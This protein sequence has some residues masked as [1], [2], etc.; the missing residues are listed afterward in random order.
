MPL[1][2]L[3]QKLSPDSE[4]GQF[5]GTANALSFAFSSIGAVLY[6]IAVG[7]L[8]IPVNR[9]FIACSVLMMCWLAFMVIRLRRYLQEYRRV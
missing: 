3:L 5:L 7:P 6:V 2:A 9:V 1:Q 4:R 8:G